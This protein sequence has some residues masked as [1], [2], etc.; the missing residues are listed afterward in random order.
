MYGL[1]VVALARPFAISLLSLG[2][3]QTAITLVVDI[4]SI[5]AINTFA[6]ISALLLLSDAHSASGYTTSLMFNARN[7]TAEAQSYSITMQRAWPR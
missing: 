2:W 7:K 6:L 1:K 3:H 4:N 5:R